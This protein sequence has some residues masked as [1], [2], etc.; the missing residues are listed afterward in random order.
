M[1]HVME[2]VP[3]EAHAARPLG[4]SEDEVARRVIC[5]NYGYDIGRYRQDVLRAQAALMYAEQAEAYWARLAREAE[6]QAEERAR[7]EQHQ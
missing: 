1:L 4:S 2:P 5:A 6:E 7:G 3:L